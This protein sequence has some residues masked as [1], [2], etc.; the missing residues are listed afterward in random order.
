MPHQQPFGAN[1][2]KEYHQLQLEEYNGI[3][4]RTALADTRLLDELPHKREI[5]R[6][7]QVP[8]EV[9]LRH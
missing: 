2:L 1:V 6:V 9:I 3:N 7:L 8:I 5:Q 4:R